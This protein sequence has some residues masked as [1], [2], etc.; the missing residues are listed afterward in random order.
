VRDRQ[1]GRAAI[2]VDG[3][4]VRTIDNYAP[5]PT[6]G[7]HCSVAGLPDGVHV[8]RIVVLGEGRPAAKGTL[9]SVES[10]GVTA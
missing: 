9:V 4:L 2:Y 10:F 6:Y 5:M 8:L 3:V 7:A 1:S